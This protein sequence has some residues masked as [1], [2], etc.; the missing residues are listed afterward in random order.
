MYE[1]F[2]TAG[3]HIRLWIYQGLKHDCW[4]RAYGE[5]ELPRW[6]LEHRLEPQ[7][8]SRSGHNLGGPSPFSERLVIPLHPPAIR[9]SAVQSQNLAGEYFDSNGN[10]ALTVIWQGERLYG[11][12]RFGQVSELGAQ[13][14]T[15]LFY[16]GGSSI[17]RIIAQ[18]DAEGRITALVL[19]DDRH[20][21]RWEKRL[22]GS[23]R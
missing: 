17:T 23:V 18:R 12:D 8:L 3:G 20:E 22:T 11:K 4:T 13:S 5:P 1:A 21:E 16:I 2:K 15:E 9:L 6:L 7:L 19:R 10:L 14:P